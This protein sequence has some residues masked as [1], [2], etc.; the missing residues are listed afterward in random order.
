MRAVLHDLDR[1]QRA[2]HDRHRGLSILGG[3]PPVREGI[4]REH[5]R[6]DL[7]LL[8]RRFLRRRRRRLGV[9]LIA[10]RIH[11]HAVQR[12][13]LLRV[14]GKDALRGRDGGLR[15]RRLLR[16]LRF[17]RLAMPRKAVQV[18]NDPVDFPVLLRV[19]IQYTAGL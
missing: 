2:A 3:I 18:K 14:H 7:F 1:G 5:A 11:R 15:G 4:D 6:W 9:A 16:R 8:R 13:V 12:A 19:H 10:V 17:G